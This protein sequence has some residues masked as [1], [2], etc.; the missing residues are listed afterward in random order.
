MALNRLMGLVRDKIQLATNLL[1]GSDLKARCARGGMALMAGTFVER[2]LRFVRTMILAKLLL[3]ADLG[4]VALVTAAMLIF[5]AV[6]EVGVRQSVIQN[7]KGDEDEYLNVAWWFQSVRTTFLF[8]VAFLLA[9]LVSRFY[10]SPQMLDLL[11]VMLISMLFNGL[12]SPRAFVLEK[13]L[14]FAKAVVLVQ[15]S[16]LLGTVVTVFLVLSLRNVW[17]IVIGFVVESLM[18]CVLSYLLCPFRPRFRIDRDCLGDILKFARGMVGLPILTLI[19]F[20]T[21][22]LVLGKMVSKELVGMYFMAFQLA[23]MPRELYARI[24]GSL[25]LPVFSKKQDDNP[26]LCRAVLKMAKGTSALF[27]PLTAFLMVCAGALLSTAYKPEY[28]EVSVPFCILCM[29]ILLRTHG[30][31]LVSTYLAIGQPQLHRGF[32]ALRAA[33]L[34][35]LLY[36]GIVLGKLVG[37]ASVLLLA[38]F[39]GFIAQIYWMRKRIGLRARDYFDCHLPGLWASLVV[40]MPVG[41]AVIG[42]VESMR[43][44]LI[45]GVC[46][47]AAACATGVLLVAK[48]PVEPQAQPCVCSSLDEPPESI[49]D[50]SLIKVGVDT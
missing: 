9:P 16:G 10:A 17:G 37:A 18:R 11:R 20:Q 1:R 49:E 44:L 42:G 5:E 32:V 50:E 27:T 15:G 36:P 43:L 47:C 7:K 35:L 6:N 21:D 14:R 33:I 19:A 23:R 45:V 26:T 30:L 4:I 25:L 2:G 8:G 38:E 13:Q 29:V 12:L 34:L 22:V 24:I 40:I 31:I 48:G 41:G 39:V 3:P 46:F 28:V